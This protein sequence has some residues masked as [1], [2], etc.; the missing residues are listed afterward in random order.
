[1]TDPGNGYGTVDGKVLAH[2]RDYRHL[3]VRLSS[4]ED[5]SAVLPATRK[6]GCPFGSLIGWKVKVVLHEQPKMSR[7]VESERP[8][9]GSLA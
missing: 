3:T 2:G 5:I 1:M 4:G 7:I 6:F 9:S 8:D